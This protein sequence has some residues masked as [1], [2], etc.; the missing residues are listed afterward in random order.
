MEKTT[1]AR[2]RLTGKQVFCLIACLALGAAHAWGSSL[3]SMAFAGL[4]RSVQ[5][6]GFF[7]LGVM[8]CPRPLKIGKASVFLSVCAVLLS[9]VFFLFSSDMIRFMT[10]PIALTCIF[11]ALFSLAGQMQHAAL[12]VRGL[13]ESFCRSFRVCFSYLNVPGRA[14]AAAMGKC[15]NVRGLG[16]GIVICIPLLI[17]VILLLA[18]ADEVFKHIFAQLFSALEALRPGPLLWKLIKTAAYTLLMFSALYALNQKAKPVNIPSRPKDT[19]AIAFVLPE[20]LL[21]VIYAVFVYI[22]L[23]Y[24]FGNAETAA[25]SG[26]YAQYARSGFF[27]LVTVTIINLA[28]ILP[29]MTL[30]GDSTIL[31]VLSGILAALTF[32]ILLSALYR[33]QLYISVYG[34]THLRILTLW[35]IVMIAGMLLLSIY[36]IVRPEKA[37]CP[38]I[39]CMLLVGWIVFAYANVDYLIAAYNVAHMP[40]EL[41]DLDHLKNLS[42]DALAAVR[43]LDAL[44]F[45]S[46]RREMLSETYH[47]TLYDTGLAWL[48][49]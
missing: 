15:R 42:P 31:R 43:R 12:T 14:A 9:L 17:C 44:V 47:P 8:L 11:L 16:V 22:Q 25:M 34:M 40:A 24:L 20:A 4:G 1:E 28:C 3:D 5:L 41:L 48:L 45:E 35:G 10:L 26:G 30:R 29:A 21:N 33:M 19:P 38:A 32:V 46:I 13:A 18:S 6:L 7:A 39:V 23:R 36:K 49:H 37:V 27:Q 2:V